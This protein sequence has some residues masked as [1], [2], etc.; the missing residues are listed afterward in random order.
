VPPVAAE[1]DGDAPGPGPL[2]DDGRGDRSG[3]PIFALR[4]SWQCDRC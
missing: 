4:A 2:A 3:S 1:I